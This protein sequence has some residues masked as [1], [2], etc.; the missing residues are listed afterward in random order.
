MTDA[1]FE[2]Q[3]LT[4]DRPVLVDFWAPWC[5]PCRLVSPIVEEL[6]RDLGERL[7]V[8][9]VNIDESVGVSARYAVFSIPTLVLFRDG[10]EVERY[11]GF[12]RKGELLKRL[13]RHL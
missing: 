6:A 9:K 13:E 10:E 11:V 5:A 2:E 7:R 3:V 4:S 1:T 12:R 8:T